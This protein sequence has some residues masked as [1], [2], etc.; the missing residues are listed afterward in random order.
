MSK[1]PGVNR[2]D[3]LKSSA[4]A[5][6]TAAAMSGITFITAPERVFG[7]NERVR[8]AVCGVRGRG[9]NHIDAY[10]KLPNAEVAAICDPDE[11]VIADRLAKMAKAGISKPAVHIDMRECLNDKNIDA[12]SIASPNHWHS[13]QAIWALQA[14]KDVYC[15]KPC[16]HNWW[17][18]KQLVDA[19][20]KYNKQVIVHGSQSRSSAALIEAMQKMRE[21]VIGD[22]YMARGLCFKWRDTIGRAT[23]EAVPKGVNYDLWTGPAPMK[24]FTKNRFHYNWHW[25]W[26]TGNGDIGNQGIH[27]MDKARWGLGVDY[28]VKVSAIGGHFMFDDDQETPNTM[29]ASFEFRDAKGQKKMMVFEVRHWIGNHEA[30]IG[31]PG[32]ND[33]EPFVGAQPASAKAAPRRRRVPDT[34]GNIYYGSKGYLSVSVYNAYKTWLG[35]EQEPGP[36][37]KAG[38][39][40]FANFIDVVRSRNKENI[41]A[42]I[43][44]GHKSCTLVHLANVSYRLGRTIHFDPATQQVKGD[45]EA[46]K[47]LNGT[48]RKG[49]EVPVKV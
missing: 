20:K 49:Y 30:D 44:E 37:R 3:F 41:N 21:G 28:P 23:E 27:E 11:N 16:S 10:G 46:Q 24:A 29:T 26:D 40:N 22:V 14:G 7:A 4:G 39:D 47:M 48:Y 5:G 13:L 32:F 9:G 45:S 31:T 19:S 43:E 33:E 1:E 35:P 38:G 34:I 42:P 15:E 17:E 18:G 25:I 36:S 6:M 8:V 12:I 2:R